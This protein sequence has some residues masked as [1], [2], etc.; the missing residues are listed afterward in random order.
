MSDNIVK[1]PWKYKHQYVCID[2]LDMQ[3]AKINVLKNA[4]TI[5][6]D[7]YKEGIYTTVYK[8]NNDNNL[9]FVIPSD[10]ESCEQQILIRASKDRM[11]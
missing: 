5:Q 4:I 7:L 9:S 11:D 1:G 10:R 2:G 3:A 8:I 6:M